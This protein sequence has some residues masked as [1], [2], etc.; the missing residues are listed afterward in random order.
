[1]TLY[2]KYCGCDLCDSFSDCL[3]SMQLIWRDVKI[4]DKWRFH[5]DLEEA[6]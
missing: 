5:E 3:H 1:M 6:A 2:L 4:L